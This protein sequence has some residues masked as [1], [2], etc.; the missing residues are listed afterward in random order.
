MAGR[1]DEGLVRALTSHRHG[2]KES[3]DRTRELEE[4]S[5]SSGWSHPPIDLK[6]SAEV[7]EVFSSKIFLQA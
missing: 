6:H 2:L 4:E 5:Q 1:V 7:I 3:E